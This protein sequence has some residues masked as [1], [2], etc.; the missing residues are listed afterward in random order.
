MCEL[1]V[2]FRIR[3]TEGPRMHESSGRRQRARRYRD[4]PRSSGSS[5]LS[6]HSSAT[7]PQGRHAADLLATVTVRGTKSKGRTHVL[8]LAKCGWRRLTT[9]RHARCGARRRNWLA[10][11]RVQNKCS[12]RRCRRCWTLRSSLCRSA[13]V[14]PSTPPSPT[15]AAPSR[16]PHRSSTRGSA[17]RWLAES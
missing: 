5:G 1:H 9:F 14:M 6:G 4:G 7:G 8:R 3:A 11:H 12:S 13:S 16:P 15:R 2:C 17:R 10:P